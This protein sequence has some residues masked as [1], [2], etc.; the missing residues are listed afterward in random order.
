MAFS[1]FAFDDNI[2][3]NKSHSFSENP[4]FAKNLLIYQRNHFILQSEKQRIIFVY[5]IVTYFLGCILIIIM[6]CQISVFNRIHPI[7]AV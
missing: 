2:C 7:S 4:K 1:T 6:G 3:C 5:Y